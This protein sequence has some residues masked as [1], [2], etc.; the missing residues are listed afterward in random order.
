M[1][2][3]RFNKVLFVFLLSI[4]SFFAFSSY[5]SA[6][7]L[8][9]VVGKG[10]SVYN[11]RKVAPYVPLV[12]ENVNC[13]ST[14]DSVIGYYTDDSLCG[15]TWK[16]T[17][18][19]AK[20]V[21]SATLTCEVTMYDSTLGPV[22]QSRRSW[23]ITVVNNGGSSST[24][25]GTQN[26]ITL[27]LNGGST[28]NLNGF[29]CS[30]STC[31]KTTTESSFVLP[32]PSRSGYTFK[33]WSTSSN[34]TNPFSCSSP[35][36]GAASVSLNGTSFSACWEQKG[37]TVESGGSSNYTWT[38]YKN[39]YSEYPTNYKT[40]ELS[41][42]KT[43]GVA[44][45]NVGYAGADN[46]KIVINSSK[47]G[48]CVVDFD[49][50]KNNVKSH[51]TINIV[52]SE[53]NSSG[54]TKPSYTPGTLN[55][56]VN[57][58]QIPSTGAPTLTGI[59]DPIDGLCDTYHV[60]SLGVHTSFNVYDP[61]GKTR[62]TNL[63]RYEATDD[64]TGEKYIS[65]CIDPTKQSP[66]ANTVYRKV[67]PVNP[68]DGIPAFAMGDKSEAYEA[69]VLSIVQRYYD[70]I[71]GSA[72]NQIAAQLAFRVY[73]ANVGFS[74]GKPFYTELAKTWT[75]KS[76]GEG[77]YDASHEWSGG[78]SGVYSKAYE[79]YVYG[80]QAGDNCYL[81]GVCDTNIEKVGIT[82][83]EFDKADCEIE[84]T[85]ITK[86]LEG[87][88]EGLDTYDQGIV[89]K[90][91]IGPK[92]FE[93]ELEID[94]TIV[95]EGG[96]LPHSGSTYKF[97]IKGSSSQWAEI[98]DLTQEIGFKVD[99][100]SK[101]DFHNV[102]SIRPT[103]GSI[104]QMILIR[105]AQPKEL[106]FILG[107]LSDLTCGLCYEDP[108]LTPGAAG[109]NE[110]RFKN[111]CCSDPK[112]T[113]GD[114]EIYCPLD[115]ELCATAT[116]SPVCDDS[117]ETFYTF[118]EG[119][120]VAEGSKIDY[121]KCVIDK[122]DEANNTY[123]LSGLEPG[124]NWY[125][126]VSCKED[127]EFTLPGKKYAT[128]GRYF[129][130]SIPRIQ[131][132]RTCVTSLQIGNDIDDAGRTFENDLKNWT[133]QAVN[134]Y[135]SLMEANAYI[136]DY[137]ITPEE[138][139]K[140]NCKWTSKCVENG[141]SVVKDSG[142]M[143]E[144]VMIKK[145]QG[146]TDFTKLEIVQAA[147]YEPKK[148]KIVNQLK[149]NSTSS[150]T[151]GIQYGKLEPNDKES[152]GA[153][154]CDFDKQ[155]HQEA[156]AEKNWEGKA[157]AALASYNEAIS[158]I[159]QGLEYI[160]QCSNWENDYQ[161]NP[162]VRYTYAESYYMDLV[163]GNNLFDIE[164]NK[165]DYDTNHQGKSGIMYCTSDAKEDDYTCKNGD[166]SG[167][168]YKHDLDI[169]HVTGSLSVGGDWNVDYD[170]DTG[171][172]SVDVPYNSSI[173]KVKGYASENSKIKGVWYTLH[174]TGD[175]VY[176]PIEGG[177][178][179]Y[180]ETLMD[181]EG[182]TS[183][184]SSNR[185]GKVMP[186]RITTKQ[187]TYEYQLM[188]TDVGQYNDGDQLGRVIGGTNKK[189]AKSVFQALTGTYNLSQTYICHYE[190]KETLCTCC[191]DD[192]EYEIVSLIACP[193]GDCGKKA[194]NYVDEYGNLSFFTRTISVNDMNP[195]NRGLGSNW[196]DDKGSATLNAIESKGEEAYENPEYSFTITSQG[197]AAL[198]SASYN[199]ASFELSCNEAGMDC[200]SA[201]LNNIDSIKGITVN[202]EPSSDSKFVHY[203]DGS[204][205]K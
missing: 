179:S 177:G 186:I 71:T 57:Y 135:N 121:E 158:N 27:N 16:L 68:L 86:Y 6:E 202:A 103:N 2:K 189:G 115:E 129:L 120:N 64:C 1:K 4:V 195:N 119:L 188:F 15:N 153:S 5:V 97:K 190:V 165:S 125:C 35:L 166:A 69:F 105:E 28:S 205:W 50:T 7:S 138:E 152:C 122:K 88:I 149:I 65:I 180:N 34:V 85:E 100:T 181:E 62:V 163:N 200:E 38:V 123:N 43:S 111:E 39:E 19:S 9:M 24:N 49:A 53:K 164:A 87:K 144:S 193:S 168:S 176:S 146:G 187:G 101:K 75:A 84:G 174:D 145:T 136:H 99:A 203:E 63:R 72:D 58:Q 160:K 37:N 55:P 74:I 104:Q 132:V 45:E 13:F 102:I 78:N 140:K 197:L 143:N 171:L 12:G 67:A 157:A 33:G 172:G 113:P 66:S 52:V 191:G 154:S 112:I 91:F 170:V 182:S 137:K 126:S 89:L 29:S 196:S 18:I 118:Y 178:S 175:M 156:Y 141:V 60:A 94:G 51:F 17:H 155:T 36:T 131:G 25:P 127:W 109:F 194:E 107:K 54:T 81:N 56:A 59:E 61:T 161:W 201:F 82:L 70:E 130:L 128:A 30:G 184:D 32:T 48:T 110:E 96:T 92:G 8:T 133:E 40:S 106:D 108:E 124:S 169:F 22:L 192:L 198:K 117:G 79:Y 23:D 46:A 83:G 3:I 14:D 150:S 31:T 167:S 148:G 134:A 73:F 95:K 159:R 42:L 185:T 26:T 47:V 199:Y 142:T 77:V 162:E 173:M 10:Q 183:T 11:G 116:W 93:Y 151:A 147:K 139:L 90:E 204:A 44:C 80:K 76:T 20:K 41:G 114:K 98:K 21:G